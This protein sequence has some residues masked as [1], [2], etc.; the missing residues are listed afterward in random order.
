MVRVR[1]GE[2]WKQDPAFRA[3]LARGGEEALEA[4]DN[5]VDALALEVDGIDLHA[6]LAEGP[7]F[8]VLA[9][10]GDAVISLLEGR[11][12]AQVFFSEND[13]ELVLIRRD[14]SALLTI[15]SLARPSRIL[16]RD[17]EVDLLDLALAVAEPLELLAAELQAMQPAALAHRAEAMRRLSGS[18]SAT[19]LQPIGPPP[20]RPE[21]L[22]S[23]S[24]K[25]GPACLFEL[26]D[27]DGLL[28][29]YRGP[30]PDLGSLLVPGKVAIR[31][32]DERP[33]LSISGS[34]Y[35]LLRD[36][37]LFAGR[38]TDGVRR[39]GEVV[40]VDLA[41]PVRNE[42]VTLTANL[43]TESIT[44]GD[45]ES[46]PCPPLPLARAILEGALEFCELVSALNGAQAENGWLSELRAS[47]EERLAH[48]TELL[49]GDLYSSRPAE[50]RT[51]RP[52]PLPL[53][54]APL[55]PGRVRR[56][57][58]RR[59]WAVEGGHPIAFGI[60]RAGDDVLL[61]ASEAEL[62]ALDTQ[63][64][65]ERWRRAEILHAAFGDGGLYAAD[66]DRLSSLDPMTGRTRW[67]RP[68]ASLPGGSLRDVVRLTGG[69]ALVVTA[70]TVT[71]LGPSD[72]RELWS[73]S[74]PTA[75]RLRPAALGP[76]VALG[77]D[78]G[79]LYALEVSTGHLSWRL[80]LPGQLAAPPLVWGGTFLA[81]CESDLGAL[82]LGVEPASGR[83]LFEV[84]LDASPVGPMTPF[85]GLLAMAGVVAGDPLIAAIDRNGQ[86]V[87]EDAPLLGR[88]PVTLVPL[89]SGLLVATSSGACAALARDGSVLWSQPARAEADLSRST[90]TPVVARGV[91][92]VGAERLQAFDTGTGQPLGHAPLVWPSRLLADGDLNVWGIDIDGSVI[93]IRL[94]THLSLL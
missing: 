55:G 29:S 10:L 83:R 61:A 68:L 87:W 73:F 75:L 23:R 50:I 77:S 80:R 34:V 11:P 74:P 8:E 27:P 2:T 62:R 14:S 65:I 92:L 48:A 57:A 28:L 1:P 60:A 32:L 36:L 71:A 41:T 53:P 47:T 4:V 93:G 63:T 46:V 52:R 5:A 21:P 51:R 59:T 76:L 40:S 89:S 79:F 7:V 6:G 67:S 37:S 64:G 66:H 81:L 22:G 49:A 38:L 86:R 88:A 25:P 91:A 16:A 19:D 45:G 35:L 82:L 30:G 72:G 44:S 54:R 9:A 13:L 26:D 3:A 39:R 85:A 17:V 94:E 56:L 20:S 69:V 42:T 58:F 90:A 31:S 24:R 43:L 78:A 18:L 70:G 12:G 33:V 15:V 84:G